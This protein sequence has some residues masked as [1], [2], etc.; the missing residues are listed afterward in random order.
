MVWLRFLYIFSGTQFVL[1][2]NIKRRW[3]GGKYDKIQSIHTIIIE[4]FLIPSD[5]TTVLPLDI[6]DVALLVSNY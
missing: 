6:I 2:F 4:Y 1:L 3:V 5:K